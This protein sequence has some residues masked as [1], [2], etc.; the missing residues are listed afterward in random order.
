MN[1]FRLQVVANDKVFFNDRCKMLI[2]PVFDGQ[3][4]VM[5]HHENMIIS[6][7]VGE[8]K[9]QKEDNTWV[10]AFVGT[11]LASIINNRVQLV[12]ETAESP[13]EIDA[14]RAREALERAEEQM[15]QKQSLKEYKQSK[16]SMA[17]AMA[18]LKIK[19]SHNI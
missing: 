8:M 9:I 6:V 17:R 14:R 7:K 3:M 15:R 16:A 19:D 5:A 2:I 1:L 4:G 13:E 10:K 12:V 18:R 11:G